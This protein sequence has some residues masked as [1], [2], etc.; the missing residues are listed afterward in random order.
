MHVSEIAGIS[1]DRTRIRAIVISTLL[2]AWGQIIWLTNIGTL[3]TYQSHEQ[4]G[5]YAIAALLVGGATVARATI[6]HAIL[7]TLLFHTLF[8][9][10]P[11]A[12][13][14]LLGSAQIGEYFREFVAYAV[15]GVTLALHAWRTARSKS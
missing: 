2:G 14:Q 7:G 6:W 4:V 1:V 9:V 11:V 8:I 12:G 13:Q 15:I 5:P 3:N 10:S